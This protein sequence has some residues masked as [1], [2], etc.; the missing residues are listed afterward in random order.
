[1]NIQ[2]MNCF[3]QTLI[4]K[5]SLLLFINSKN[6]KELKESKKLILLCENYSKEEIIKL[7]ETEE[8]N[9]GFII[10]EEIK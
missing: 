2:D 9:C 3:K 5:L 7:I 4:E 1:M 8:Y 10:Q 6:E